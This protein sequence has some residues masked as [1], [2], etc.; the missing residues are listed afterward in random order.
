MALCAA[1]LAACATGED[2]PLCGY[3][4]PPSRRSL[5]RRASGRDVSSSRLLKAAALPSSWDSREHGWVTPVKDQS[6]WGTCWTF[7]SYATLETQLLKSGRG[8]WDF[9]EKNLA[10]LNGFDIYFDDGGNYDMAAAYLLRWGGAVMETNDEYRTS[11]ESWS[12]HPSV[13]LN[14]AIHVQNVVWVPGRQGA[15]DND[16]LKAAIMEYGAVAVSYCHEDYCCTSAGAYYNNIYTNSATEC[17]DNHAVTVVGWDD[18]YPRTKFRSN[19]RPPGD[20]AWL[21]KNSW[22]TEY[23]DGGYLHVSYYD[24]TFAMYYAGNVFVP[25]T[26]EEDYTAV[27]GYDRLGYV[28][29]DDDARY[30][31]EAAVFTS[32][33]NEEVA[34]VGLYVM[35]VPSSFTVS[36]YTNVTRGGSSPI[37]GGALASSTSGTVD[38][39]G[40]VTIPL[41][42]P[43]PLADR[44]NFAVVYAQNGSPVCH[45]ISFSY[46][47]YSS[48]NPQAGNTYLGYPY[49]SWRNTYTNWMDLAMHP[50]GPTIA[51]LKAYTRL[52][53]EGKRD[54]PS[55]SDDGTAMLAFLSETNAV[56]YAQFGESFGA[57]ANLVGA[58]GR[59]LWASWLAGFDPSDSSDNVLSL[60]ID[61][62]GGRPSL[63][64]SPDLGAD[65]SYTIWG[66]NGLSPSS[67]WRVVPQSELDTT[68]AKF[69]KVSV[70]QKGE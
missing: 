65:R 18:A 56:A 25:A 41:P 49:R 28:G 5:V 24:M 69:F 8:G 13:P 54:G 55:P 38:R 11:E 26:E 10:S 22:G 62:T 48:C 7:A 58:N 4:P 64:W 43:V 63:L 31:L 60:S 15:A 34:A 36:L 20:G 61:M 46:P 45:A 47:E 12:A 51:C 67:A 2:S 3:R 39:G 9:S 50:D 29:Y 66:R 37:E 42:S 19:R 16:D 57:F 40:Y 44:S 21:V 6:P 53:A 14:P 32:A 70:G 27:Y 1:M 30:T 35:G 23:G 68:S 33:W 52:R 59:S 17:Y